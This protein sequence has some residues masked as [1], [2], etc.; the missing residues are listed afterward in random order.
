MGQF[1]NL[2]LRQLMNTAGG[3]KRFVKM[4]HIYYLFEMLSSVC[5]IVFDW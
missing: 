5:K 1:F 4:S 3:L 2:I